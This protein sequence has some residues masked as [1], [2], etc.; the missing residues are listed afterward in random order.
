MCETGNRYESRQNPPKSRCKQDSQ[1][2]VMGTGSTVSLSCVTSCFSRETLAIFNNL[3]LTEEEQN[4]SDAIITAIKRH[5]DG[6]IN[7]SMEQ[8]KLRQ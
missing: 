6:L 5:V 1:N 7:E 4:N 2:V 8:C 3:G